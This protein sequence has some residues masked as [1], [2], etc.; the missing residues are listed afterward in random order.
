FIES[1]LIAARDSGLP[2]TRS[3]SDNGRFTQGGADAILANMYVNAGVFTKEG[4]GSGG[5]SASSYNSCSGVAVAA[6]PDA[7]LAADSAATRLMNSPYYRLADSFPQSFRADNSSSPE[8]IFLVKFIAADGLGLHVVM[9]G[10]RHPG[11]DVQFVRCRGQA[12]ASGPDRT[13]VQRADRRSRDGPVGR[14]TRLH[15][16]D[17]QHPL[18][19]RGGRA[20]N[21]QVAG[22]RGPHRAKQRQR[23]RV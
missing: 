5:I 15:R 11:A 6:G 13:S 22:R 18:G 2:A 14:S 7:C 1:E 3:Q 17:N 10:L 12:A 23:L 21:L 4:A 16:L 20:P 8:N 19:D 9:S